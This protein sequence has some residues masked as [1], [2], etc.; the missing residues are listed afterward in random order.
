M[1]LYEGKEGNKITE[2]SAAADSHTGGIFSVAWSPD[3]TQLIS[4]SSD[5]TVKLWDVGQTKV[6]QTFQIGESLGNLDD[7]QVGCLWQ[8]QHM[9]SV[10]L[11]GDINYFDPRAGNRPVQVVKGH[12]KAVIS[13]ACHEQ[14]VY[15]GSYD[16]KQYA[17]TDSSKGGLVIPG[18]GHSNQVNQMSVGNG[19]VYSVAMD[20][21]IR[22]FDAKS[23]KFS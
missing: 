22:S 23:L 6:L 4:A 20:D 16:G 1:F 8:G 14:T 7:Q 12:Q 3:S 15:S 9:V 10:S 5:T 13:L 18:A 19:Q 21:S 11:S 2:L 17:W